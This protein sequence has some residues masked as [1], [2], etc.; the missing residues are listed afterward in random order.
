MTIAKGKVWMGPEKRFGITGDSRVVVQ[1]IE[2]YQRA[3][4]FFGH[5]I[6]LEVPFVGNLETAPAPAQSPWR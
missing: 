4:Q 5:S 6:D 1:P 3:N 2:F